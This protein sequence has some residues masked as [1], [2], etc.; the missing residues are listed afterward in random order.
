MQVV[1]F[2]FDKRLKMKKKVG[3]KTRYII[4]Q[5]DI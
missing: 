5:K 3:K 4:I 2:P 1:F